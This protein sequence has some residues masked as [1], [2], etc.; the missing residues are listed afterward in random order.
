MNQSTGFDLWT[1]PIRESSGRLTV[2][3]AE[4]FLRTPAFETYPTF[5]PDGGWI[6]YGSNESGTWEVYVRRFPDN[7]TKV[8]VSKSGGRIPYWS[9]R[10]RE[11]L[12]RTDDQRIMAA[13]YAIR[14]ESCCVE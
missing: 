10:R 12:Y 3:N 6:A 2:G 7:G 9:A 8:Q 4:P 14:G 11:L 13:S 5:S 1:V